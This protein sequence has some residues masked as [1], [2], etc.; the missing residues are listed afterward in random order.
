MH[1]FIGN[2]NIL[3][4]CSYKQ[5]GSLI[6]IC[7]TELPVI[8]KMFKNERLL[9]SKCNSLKKTFSSETGIHKIV[10]TYVNNHILN[11]TKLQVRFHSHC[12][13]MKPMNCEV[14]W[15]DVRKTHINQM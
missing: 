10:E 6:L 8:S 1:K 14:N 5:S 3:T 13:K 15:I 2:Q 12:M 4:E 11:D 9:L 7:T